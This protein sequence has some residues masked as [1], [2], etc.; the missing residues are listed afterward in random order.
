MKIDQQSHL[1]S[2]QPQVGEQL[3]FVD[4]IDSL[5]ALN[6][7]DDRAG[8]NEID[9][10]SQVDLLSIIKDRQ[11]DLTCN[12]EPLVSKLVYQTA[13]AIIWPVTRFIG[14]VIC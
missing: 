5:N 7:D 11:S 12:R 2:T 8:H 13:A 4:R 10:V 6:F 9:A 3:G 1:P 14:G